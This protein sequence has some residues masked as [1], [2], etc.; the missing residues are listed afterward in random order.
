MFF[1]ELVQQQ[2]CHALQ[3]ISIISSNEFE[4]FENTAFVILVCKLENGVLYSR[5]LSVS[6]VRHQRETI[7]RSS[8]ITATKII[9]I[10]RVVIRLDRFSHWLNIWFMGKT[11][12]RY[13]YR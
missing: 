7:N 11:C 1:L 2:F 9:E 10:L 6:D 12:K 8:H 13:N 4:S 5:K 3:R